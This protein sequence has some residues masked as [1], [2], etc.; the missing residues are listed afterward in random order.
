MPLTSNTRRA[1]LLTEQRC[2]V[3]TVASQQDISECRCQF[4]QVLSVSEAFF[5]SGLQAPSQICLVFTFGRTRVRKHSLLQ[6]I[7]AEANVSLD[8]LYTS[9]SR[10]NSKKCPPMFKNPPKNHSQRLP[11]KPAKQH[12]PSTALHRAPSHLISALYAHKSAYTKQQCCTHATVWTS[13]T[14]QG[15]EA[16]H[17]PS[18]SH[19][20]GKSLHVSIDQT[21]ADDS[22]GLYIEKRWNR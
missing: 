1:C 20:W 21:E 11:C 17:K 2:A 7:N 16:R 14:I 19:Q 12:L 4:L 6:Q 15:R 13:T 18:P 5:S 10:R 9:Y 3:S 8:A 22:V